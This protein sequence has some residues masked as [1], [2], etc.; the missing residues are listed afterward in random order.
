MQ[1]SIQ[2]KKEDQNIILNI[3]QHTKKGNRKQL[4]HWVG[5]SPNPCS[6]VHNKITPR[7]IKAGDFNI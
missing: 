1:F 7:S 3:I 4:S 2:M 5:G 6:K